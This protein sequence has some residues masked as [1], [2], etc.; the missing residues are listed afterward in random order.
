MGGVAATAG[1]RGCQHPGADGDAARLFLQ[2]SSPWSF[3]AGESFRSLGLFWRC[4]FLEFL[5]TAFK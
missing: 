5:E 4:A 3:R 1:H 2:I